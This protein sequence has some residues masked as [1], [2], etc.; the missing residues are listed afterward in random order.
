MRIVD[1]KKEDKFICQYITL[2][3]SYC[4][5]LLTSP[6]DMKGTEKWLKE[7]GD[8]VEILGLVESGDLSGVS[9]L[10]LDKNGEIAF[11]S[12]DPNKGTGD[13]LLKIIEKAARSRK[14]SYIWA[15]VLKDNSIAQHVFE[16]N[17]FIKEKDD[18]REYG[19]VMKKGVFYRKGLS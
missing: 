2:R 7:K 3:N 12:K 15:W 16:K 10:Y 5:M 17:G 1:L 19:G 18:M 13:R 11:F 14:V 9:I 6:V 8:N 4:D